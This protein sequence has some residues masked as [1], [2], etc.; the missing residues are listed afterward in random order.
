MRTLILVLIIM[1]LISFAINCATHIHTIGKG[2]A[3][4]DV[5]KVKARQ[6]Y[7]LWGL[8]PINDVDSK[9]MAGNA[10]DYEIVIA[11]K[12]IDF[13]INIVT[14]VI[15]IN[16]RPVTVTKQKSS[17]KQDVALTK[18]LANDEK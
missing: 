6:W 4:E 17:E 12:P 7:I 11:V 10:A 13:L 14:N 8:V 16:C 2:P 3:T 5:V 15:S 18:Q 9:M 1:L